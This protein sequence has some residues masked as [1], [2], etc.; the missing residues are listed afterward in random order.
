MIFMGG[1]NQIPVMMVWDKRKAISPGATTTCFSISVPP[2]CNGSLEAF[3]G[4]AGF[5]PP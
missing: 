2:M 1:G 4:G 3:T 5:S